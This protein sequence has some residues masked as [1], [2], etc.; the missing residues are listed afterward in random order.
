MKIIIDECV[1]NIVKKRLPRFG[2][3]TVRLEGWGGKKNGELLKLVEE[4]FDVFVTSDKNLK[5]QQNV[6]DRKL[7]IILLPSNQVP[8]V[9][10]LL[11]DIEIAFDSVEAGEFVEILDES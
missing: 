4:K 8:V 1:P 3:S 6:A 5:Y 7:A 11:P 9:Q 10:R 2:I